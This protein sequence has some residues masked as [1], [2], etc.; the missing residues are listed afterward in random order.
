VGAMNNAS[1]SSLTSDV[2]QSVGNSNASVSP[3][4]TVI[5]DAVTDVVVWPEGPTQPGTDNPARIVS[6]QGGSAANVA[7]AAARRGAQTGITSRFI[8]QI[9]TDP[10]GDHLMRV[11][12]A[13]GVDTCVHRTGVSGKVV[14]IVDADGER[15]MYPDRGSAAELSVIPPHWLEGTRILHVPFYGLVAEPMRSAVLYAISAVQAVGA[16]VSL[17]LSATSVI[18]E[19][20][21]AKVRHL[22]QQIGP[23]ILFANAAEAELIDL[24]VDPHLSVGIHV[25]KNGAA[26]ATVGTWVPDVVRN[27]FI[28]EW[29][30]VPALEVTEV[31]DTTGAGDRFAAGFLTA[32][33]GGADPVEAAQAGHAAAASSLALPG[34]GEMD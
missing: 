29:T 9:G 12:T 2:P 23:H 14:V 22:L 31:R 20:G 30:E 3:I 18:Q 13:A 11:L 19:M 7:V 34:S 17:D 4:L 21:V 16:Q 5:G 6:T 10:A 1:D 25:I 24:D 27:D 26:P 15:T 32:R 33:L 28:V 8:G